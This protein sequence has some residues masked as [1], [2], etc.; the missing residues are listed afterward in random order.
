MRKIVLFVVFVVLGLVVVVGGKWYYTTAIETVDAERG[1][2]GMG[3]L[4]MWIEINSRMPAAA[5][6]WACDTLMAREAEAIGARRAD[7]FPHSCGPDFGTGTTGSNYDMLLK[8]NLD[9]VTAGADETK[10]AA[11]SACV[12]D[13]MASAVTP[14][15][16]AAVNDDLGSPAASKVTIALNESARACQNAE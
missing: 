16:I 14:D 11:I 12:A 13:R 8:M 15:E 9:P 7:L 4:E 10:A 5:R 2:Y 3:G 1:V 6:T